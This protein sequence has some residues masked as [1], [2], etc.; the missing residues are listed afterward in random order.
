MAVSRKFV[1]LVLAGS[2]LLSTVSLAGCSR[3][4]TGTPRTVT[5][6]SGDEAFYDVAS[7]DI[8]EHYTSQHIYGYVEPRVLYYGDTEMVTAIKTSNMDKDGFVKDS[9]YYEKFDYEGNKI[10][11]V[12]QGATCSVPV[13]NVFVADGKYYGIFPEQPQSSEYII[14]NLDFDKEV[15]VEYGRFSLAK[16]D[17]IVARLMPVYVD[18]NILI[19]ADSGAGVS[20]TSSIISLDASGEI[21]WEKDFDFCIEK[22]LRWDDNSILMCTTDKR[23]Y[24]YDVANFQLTE[25]SVD[26][27]LYS[28][29]LSNGTFLDDGNVCYERTDRIDVLNLKDMSESVLVDYNYCDFSM[30]DASQ[31]TVEYLS[32]DRIVLHDTA[33][34]KPGESSFRWKTF[35]LL[36]SDKNPYAG[37]P[38][39]EIAQ[40]QGVDDLVGAGVYEYN[41]SQSEY[42]AY[43]TGRYNVDGDFV[44]PD[45]YGDDLTATQIK[46]LVIDQLKIDILNGEGPDVVIGLGDTTAINY[47]DWLCDFNKL[48]EEDSD[49]SADDY[50]EN[51]FYAFQNDSG[52]FQIPLEIQGY[53]ILANINNGYSTG[54]GFTYDGYNSLVEA[55]DGFDMIGYRTRDEYMECLYRSNER[56]FFDH[57]RPNFDCDEFRAM[58]DYLKNCVTDTGLDPESED[59][60]VINHSHPGYYYV[61]FYSFYEDIQYDEFQLED[62]NVFGIPSL[63]SQGPVLSVSN[64]IAIAT[65]TSDVDASWGFVKLMLSEKVQVHAISNPINKSAYYTYAQNSLEMIDFMIQD[66]GLMLRYKFPDSSIEKYRL[67]LERID[68]TDAIDT[69]IYAIVCEEMP[70]YFSDDKTIDQVIDIIN[71]RAQLVVDERG[72]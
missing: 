47:P 3:S 10:G 46:Q 33:S 71:R 26:K 35:V 66:L 36:H 18:G 54:N 30:S 53:G 28:K 9:F 58:A 5:Y 31:C 38:M 72:T 41:H 50:F 8:S 52:L 29:Y 59:Y 13:T 15:L 24:T 27:Q 55:N 37:R 32:S 49:I 39:L 40:I 51:G 68:H 63:G 67:M 57:G 23:Y 61:Y 21:K 44:V 4:G 34:G 70:A 6:V 45:I 69:E 11:L 22:C 42:F 7:F 1:S 2:I 20:I 14:Y 25:I 56:F 12:R 64:T 19:S 62:W 16:T 60:N 43:I 48:I 65:C 17:G